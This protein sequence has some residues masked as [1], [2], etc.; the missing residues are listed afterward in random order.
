MS[1]EQAVV[2]IFFKLLRAGL[3]ESDISGI[4]ATPEAWERIFRIAREQAVSG[5]VFKG[6]TRLPE[7]E[8]PPETL[9]MGLL[10][11]VNRISSRT[12]HVLKVAKKLLADFQAA[13]FHPVVM[14]GPAVGKYYP[15]PSFRT[16]GDID[17][18]LSGKEYGSALSW[19]SERGIAASPEPDGSHLYSLE[20]VTVEHHPR[21]Y[22]VH[23]RAN[24]LPPVPSA[25][26]ELLMLSAHILKHAIGVGVGL[27]QICDIAQAY[28]MLQGKYDREALGKFIKTAGLQQWNHLL[29]SFL[30]TYLEVPEETLPAYRSVDPARL[31]GIV[32]SGGNFGQYRKGLKQ[33][34]LQTLLAFVR[35]LPFSL[36]YAPRETFWTMAELAKGNLH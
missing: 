33:G 1:M 23:V 34:K 19:L 25:E 16:S 6:A 13:G 15:A 21:Y 12:D 29:C 28:R 30:E 17:L 18:F 2:E 35:R 4:G 3:Y 5:I 31:F 22:D 36:R 11:E 27:R 7:E 10:V 14:K 26:A 20:G 8:M 32:F 9:R 24:R